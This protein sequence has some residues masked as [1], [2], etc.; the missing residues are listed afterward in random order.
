MYQ[1]I[2]LF[3]ALR[4]LYSKKINQFY[5]YINWFTSLSIIL[6]V[7]T[8][9]IILSTMNGFEREL[10][11]NLLYFI[12]HVIVTATKGYTHVQNIPHFLIK[13][14]YNDILYIKPIVISDTIIQSIQGISFGIMLGINPNH[15]EPLSNYIINKNSIK[16]LISDQ[17]YVIIG[18]ALAKKLSVNI[19]DQIRLT[20]PSVNQCALGSNFPSQRLFTILDIY[21]SNNEIDNYQILV[22]QH[23]AAKLMHYPDQCITGWRIWLHNPFQLKKYNKLNISK[24]WHWKD[25]SRTKGSLFQAVKIEKNMM[26][27]FFILISLLI[28]INVVSFLVLLITDKK[29]EIAI[30]KT[31]GFNRLQSMML[32]IILGMHNSVISIVYGTIL[33]IFLSKNLNQILHLFNVFPKKLLIPIEIQYF[34]IININCIICLIIMLIIL[35]PSWYIASVHPAQILCYEQKH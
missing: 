23:D 11:K 6:S 29:K 35:Y 16:K 18:S 24:N 12:P 4:Y 21:V 25:W 33:G 19:N 13:T 3:V 27:L 5:K 14:I 15:F 26:F 32:F 2:V 8:I 31:Y 1:P 20:I 22:N 10:K 28:G 7:M 34:Q 30:L 17:Y 9:I